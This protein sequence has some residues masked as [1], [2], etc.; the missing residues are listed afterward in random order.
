MVIH[1]RLRPRTYFFTQMRI[2]L[3]FALLLQCG[4]QSFAQCDS[5]F[6]ITDTKKALSGQHTA[7]VGVRVESAVK[8]TVKLISQADTREIVEKKYTS[9]GAQ[10]F[11]FDGLSADKQYK[12][13]LEFESD[14]RAICKKRETEFFGLSKNKD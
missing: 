14:S 4:V 1:K 6:S 13:A 10:T 3:F 5:K 7:A 12:V 9:S 8:Y 11:R 2:L